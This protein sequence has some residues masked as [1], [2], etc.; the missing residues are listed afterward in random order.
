MYLRLSQASIHFIN[1]GT[2][3]SSEYSSRQALKNYTAEIT[4][5][6]KEVCKELSDQI[7]D[8]VWTLEENE[9]DSHKQNTFILKEYLTDATLTLKIDHRFRSYWTYHYHNIDENIVHSVKTIDTPAFKKYFD[10][11]YSEDG[12]KIISSFSKRQLISRHVVDYLLH[13]TNQMRP[14]INAIKNTKLIE[15]D[16][17]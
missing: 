6:I 14:A 5:I 10:I 7:T 13:L 17:Q 11:R 4:G 12:L 1:R 2:A 16:I 15:T 9:N 3:T 8:E